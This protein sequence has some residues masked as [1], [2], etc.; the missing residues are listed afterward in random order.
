MS[1]DALGQKKD[2]FAVIQPKATDFSRESSQEPSSQT[3]SVPAALH[4]EHLPDHPTA[5]IGD[6]L[7]DDHD[8]RV[9][10]SAPGLQVVWKPRRRA[11]TGPNR[12]GTKSM[13][14]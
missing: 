6:P 3:G 13:A 8:R 14:K 9:G 2:A 1:T 4:A 12:P 10:V 7:K 11:W 5:A